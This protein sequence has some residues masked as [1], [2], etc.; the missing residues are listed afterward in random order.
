MAEKNSG[1]HLC[2]V[3]GK[4]EFE[5]RSSMELCDVCNWLDDAVSERESDHAGGGNYM[6]LNQAKEAYKRGEIVQ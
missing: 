3:C 2:P 4:F 1:A 6:T 5:E